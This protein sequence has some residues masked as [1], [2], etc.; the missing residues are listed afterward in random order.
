MVPA[1]RGVTGREAASDTCSSDAIGKELARATLQQQQRQQ[2]QQQQQS[3]RSDPPS[4]DSTV[5][6]ACPWG[7]DVHLVAAG[8]TVHAL[9]SVDGCRHALPTATRRRPLERSGGYGNR[10]TACGNDDGDDCV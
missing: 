6:G 5:C 10:R 2:Q 1:A 8:S 7:G 4:I 3:L 9:E